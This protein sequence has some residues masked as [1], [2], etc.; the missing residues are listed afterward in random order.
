MLIATCGI[1]SHTLACENKDNFKTDEVKVEKT[2]TLK[3]KLDPSEVTKM[4][5]ESLSAINKQI[6]SIQLD[7]EN[8]KQV[9]LIDV[10]KNN[11]IVEIKIDGQ[12]GKVVDNRLD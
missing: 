8:D 5:M 2:L 11:E 9:Y 12:N 4:A 7:E 3:V 6:R 1:T 10:K